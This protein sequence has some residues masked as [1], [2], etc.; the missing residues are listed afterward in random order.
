M[1]RWIIVASTAVL[2]VLLV[3]MTGPVTGQEKRPY[4]GHL[5]KD[6][7]DELYFFIISEEDCPGTQG[8]YERVIEGELLRARIKRK[9]T[10]TVDEVILYCEIRCIETPQSS[11]QNHPWAIVL[12]FAVHLD[13]GVTEP[14]EDD[15][16]MV[17]FYPGYGMFG[18]F[19]KGTLEDRLKDTLRSKTADA[20]TDYLEVNINQ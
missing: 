5:K 18:S 15:R 16:L 14:D 19:S 6:N 10:W 11:F 12:H 2:A 4:W 20:L 8:S 3:T 13:V 9:H 7:P 17:L 1:T